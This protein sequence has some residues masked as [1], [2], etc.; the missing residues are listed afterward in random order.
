MQTKE[1]IKDL[2]DGIGI[3]GYEKKFSKT[4]KELLAGYCE[5]TVLESNG[6]VI[7][8]FK[9]PDIS[10]KTILLEAHIDRIGLMVSEISEDGFLKFRALG[11]VDERVLPAS[12]VYILGTEMVY[13]V[14]GAVP[15]HLKGMSDGEEQSPKISDMLIDT[16]LTKEEL[17]EKV[18][19]GAP[20]M[21]KSEF[22][23]LTD[24]RVSSSGLDNRSGMAAIFGCL[25]RLKD[26]ELSVNLVVAFTV[27]EE[28]GLQ[29][30]WALNTDIDID[31]AVIIDVTHGRTH[32]SQKTDTFELGQGAVICRGPNFDRKTAGKIIE[33][34]K[35]KNIPYEIEVAQG[36]SGTNAWALQ[37]SGRG[38][39]CALISI[40]LRYMHTTVETIAL[41]DVETTSKLLFEIVLG[42]ERLA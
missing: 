40:P 27:G 20:I 39:A 21:M 2:T 37:V 24:G 17:L 23:E 11:G 29:G 4:V 8:F 32:D 5:R 3:S 15:P 6:S 9:E 10:K 34:A 30:A 35:A 1:I 25:D 7:G 12:E 18:W 28:L 22:L 38:I 19:V 16:G 26:S 42:G 41:E 13:G 36:N 14:I 33:L 31:L